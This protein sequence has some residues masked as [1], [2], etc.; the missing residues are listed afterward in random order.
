MGDFFSEK[1]I[2]RF[3][4]SDIFN[5]IEDTWGN[6]T[7]K[8][9][10]NPP[11]FPIQFPPL[12]SRIL[13]LQKSPFSIGNAEIHRLKWWM[14]YRHGGSSL[15]NHVKKL[16]FGASIQRVNWQLAVKHPGHYKAI[17]NKPWW[18]FTTRNDLFT[19]M[20][21]ITSDKIPWKSWLKRE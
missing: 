6:R 7:C 3:K 21:P 16:N 11:I 8:N 18:F 12:S 10:G 19:M 2:G 17:G 4:S 20:E 15:V 9:E 1:A 14:F 13:T 5:V